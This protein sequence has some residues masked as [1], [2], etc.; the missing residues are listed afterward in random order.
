MAAGHWHTV[1]VAR[2]RVRDSPAGLL[3]DW[4]KPGVESLVRR[5]DGPMPGHSGRAASTPGRRNSGGLGGARSRGQSD[6]AQAPAP[7]RRRRGPATPGRLSGPERPASTV[8]DCPEASEVQVGG[9]QPQARPGHG[10]GGPR[11][12]GPGSAAAE[13]QA[14]RP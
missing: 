5:R 12:A 4:P 13:P 7:G 10:A 9:T 3:S 1:T 8:T 6:L 14:L 2:V 11:P